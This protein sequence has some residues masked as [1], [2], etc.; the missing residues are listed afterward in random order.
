[1]KL[2]LY[3]RRLAPG[4]RRKNWPARPSTSATGG[5]YAARRGEAGVFPLEN[6]TERGERAMTA[7]HGGRGLSMGAAKRTMLRCAASLEEIAL[8]T[9]LSRLPPCRRA[10]GGPANWSTANAAPARRARRRARARIPHGRGGAPGAQGAR[11]HAQG[12]ARGAAHDRGTHSICVRELAVLPDGWIGWLVTLNGILCHGSAAL[13][14]RLVLNARSARRFMILDTAV[15]V[16][17]GLYVNVC[18]PFQPWTLV[19]SAVS[20]LAWIYNGHLHGVRHAVLHVTL[21][22]W[23]LCGLL[24]A[25][26]ITKSESRCVVIL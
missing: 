8:S 16:A 15:N 1:M 7:P 19:F 11:Y 18:T 10:W 23:M 26:E 9:S 24:F 4:R 14:I 2:G 22:Q 3:P 21:V 13:R 17:L 25:Y 6:E 12:D 20:T 5:A